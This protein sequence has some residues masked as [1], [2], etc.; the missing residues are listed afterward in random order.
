MGLEVAE[1]FASLGIKLDQGQIDHA[2]AQ[3]DRI[4]D[5]V[6]KAGVTGKKAGD[7]AAEGWKQFGEA[8]ELAESALAGWVGLEGVKA[9][10]ELTE[11]V[12]S[13]TMQLQHLSE[14]TGIAVD[15]LRGL[16]LAAKLTGSDVETLARSMQRVEFGLSAIGKHA[17]GTIT[18]LRRLGIDANE[19]KKADMNGQ[20]GLLADKFERMADPNQKIALAMQLGGHAMVNLIPLLSKGREHLAE[21]TAEAK[22]YGYALDPKQAEAY[23][24][25]QAKL[26]LQWDGLK[27]K[28]VELLLPALQK[29]GD[30]LS[31]VLGFIKEHPDALAAALKILAIAAGVVTLALGTTAIKA[32]LAKKA[33]SGLLGTIAPLVAVITAT[34]D[35]TE[36]MN[37]EFGRGPAIITAVTGAVIALSIALKGLQLSK[38]GGISGAL[39]GVGKKLLGVGAGGAAEGVA[40]VAGGAAEGAGIAGGAA[41]AAGGAGLAGAAAL[42]APFILGLAGVGVAAKALSPDLGTPTYAHGYDQDTKDMR[43]N[44]NPAWTPTLEKTSTGRDF[45]DREFGTHDEKKIDQQLTINI[46]VPI[47]AAATADEIRTHVQNHLEDALREAHANQHHDE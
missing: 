38:I 6:T 27:T 29:L 5:A 44:Y 24:E 9:I 31:R 32:L 43:A 13:Q 42:A 2:L 19:F 8:A 26:G 40:G 28:V 47:T 11:K 39:V 15:D 36:W 17:G 16:Q 45:L 22:E 20:L 21:L 33:F 23:E 10:G 4:A 3:I 37:D 18:A 25:Q 14:R 46:N 7:E 12:V 34:I 35:A 1:I 41:E 30:F